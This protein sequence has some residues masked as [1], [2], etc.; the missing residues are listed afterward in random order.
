[1][2]TSTRWWVLLVLGALSAI[3]CFGIPMYVI[4][5]FRAQ[6]T[7]ELAL[8]LSVIRIRPVLSIIAVLIAAGAA[9][10]LWRHYRTIGKR[11][12]VLQA[13]VLAA[14]FGALSWVNV[15]EI[16][17][18]GA[19]A[20][21]F[22]SAKDAKLEPDEMVLAVNVERASR[23]YPVGYIAYHHIVNDRIGSVPI[24]ATY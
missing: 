16:M 14:V 12:L 24:V 2:G 10:P 13:V 20:P 18:H 9:I 11:L 1:M 19:G 5:P 7:R 4:R 23:A 15:Y 6:G 17:F 8:A 3:A 22:V 21:Q